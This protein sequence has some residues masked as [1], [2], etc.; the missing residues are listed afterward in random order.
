MNS[1]DMNP[2]G[3]NPHGATSQN[4]DSRCP[5]CTASVSAQAM[6]CQTCRRDFYLFKP[7]QA[8]IEAEVGDLLFT[9]VNAARFLK[10]DPESALRTTNRKFRHRFQWVERELK[11]RGRTPRESSL[12]EMDALWNQAKQVA[13]GTR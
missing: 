1:Q 3:M 9:V 10:V 5:Y 7:L 6:V 12:E 2:Q 4:G 11:A 8:R 13:G